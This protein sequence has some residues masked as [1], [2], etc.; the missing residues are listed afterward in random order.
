MPALKSS[1]SEITQL[2]YSYGDKTPLLQFSLFYKSYQHL[3]RSLSEG[4]P[5]HFDDQ[6]GGETYGLTLFIRGTLELSTIRPPT[7]IPKLASAMIAT[8]AHLPP[9]M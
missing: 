5:K 3:T 8:S 6:G 7:P 9:A 1:R 4:Y 2:S